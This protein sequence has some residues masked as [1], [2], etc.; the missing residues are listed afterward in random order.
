[1]ER[2]GEDEYGNKFYEKEVISSDSREFNT[3]GNQF[4]SSIN[5]KIFTGLLNNQKASS[6]K[7]KRVIKYEP[8]DYFDDSNV[9][10]AID[11][12]KDRFKINS[13]NDFLK[14][15]NG[16]I[17]FEKEIM[18]KNLDDPAYN[19]RVSLLPEPNEL[20]NT[21]KKPYSQN[22]Y[23]HHPLNERYGSKKQTGK[24]LKGLEQNQNIMMDSKMPEST[25]KIFKN[26]HGSHHFQ[27][28]SQAKIG[29]ETV[30]L[31]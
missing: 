27:R 12:I 6:D 14:Y 19:S 16:P 24:F 25:R 9:N 22:V 21:M 31:F 28:V 30:F 17:D 3:D 1:M 5:G 29:K 8:L 20:S 15:L 2:E 13:V 11:N 10:E 4:W 26:F 7:P 18:K 23:S